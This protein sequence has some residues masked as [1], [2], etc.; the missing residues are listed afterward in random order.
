MPK[1][2]GAVI[3]QRQSVRCTLHDC[4]TFEAAVTE[5]GLDS[6]VKIE[7]YRPT[8]NAESYGIMVLLAASLTL[9]QS[10]ALDAILAHWR[11]EIAGDCATEVPDEIVPAPRMR[12][13]TLE[14]HGAFVERV[15]ADMAA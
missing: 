4:Y 14:E 12:R 6:V 2:R 9:E 11:S 3:Q 10:V 7:F 5:Q 8:D 13:Q 15:R 1:E